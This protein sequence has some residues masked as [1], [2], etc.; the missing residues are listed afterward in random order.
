ML[1]KYV[2]R[3]G[4]KLTYQRDFPTRLRTFYP[5]KTFTYPLGLTPEQMTES[6]IA[7][8]VLVATE[9]YELRV[10]MI[11]NSDP[12][13]FDSSELEQAAIEYLRKR[14]LSKGQFLKVVKDMN[15]SEQEER[16]QQQLQ[17][18][19][20]DFSDLAIP[21]FD[22]VLDKRNRGEELTFQDRVIGEAW[23]AL[24][25]KSKAKPQTLDSLWEVYADYR[26]IDP[27]S[28]NGKRT[29][30]RWNRWLA[31]VGNVV[32]SHGT[33]DH[34]HDGLD[35]Y[36][37]QR[38]ADNVSGSSIRRELNDIVACLRYASKRYRY[39]WVIELPQIPKSTPKPKRVISQEEQRQLLAYCLASEG[40]E[41]SISA[42]LLLMLQGAMMPSEIARLNQ[43]KI[44]LVGDIPL[45]IVDGE[46]KTNA[47]K[48]VV[49]IVLGVDFLRQYIQQAID[50]LNRTTESN[51]SHRIA[52]FLESATGNPYLTGHCCRHTF[53]SNVQANRVSD[54]A[55]ATIA[56]WSGSGAGLSENM[57]KYG[58]EG[59]AQSEVIAALWQDSCQIHKHLM[60]T[61]TLQIGNVVRLNTM[62]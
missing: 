62:R 54:I 32:I 1:P 9:A 6:S 5:K 3:Q 19:E 52:R 11:T 57:L 28:R 47:R 16:L 21:E 53:K 26:G 33:L 56:G 43:D 30:N 60:H 24:H 48:R 13:A 55:G 39:K 45:V 36:V 46:T 4:S 61:Q 15:L 49:P 58:A 10:K 59:L 41:A 12:E 42:C 7:K 31:L 18:H 23:L 40:P 8:A 20:S 34:I 50:W 2:R 35:A 29:I 38:K 44:R 27:N 51:H 14:N 17:P 25:N 37:T 22:D